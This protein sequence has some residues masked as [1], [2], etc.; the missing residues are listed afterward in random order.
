MLFLG[1]YDLV[2]ALEFYDFFQYKLIKYIICKY[3]TPSMICPFILCLFFTM[4]KSFSLIS[5]S[6]FIFAFATCVFSV[7]QKN[8]S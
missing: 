4:K 2:F 6:S 5:L 7:Y 1:K 8:Y 3:F